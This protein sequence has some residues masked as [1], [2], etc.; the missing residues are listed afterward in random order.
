MH[1]AKKA[2]LVIAAAGVAAGA[3]TTAASAHD[4]QQR[5]EEHEKAFSCSS[6]AA[7]STALSPGLISG[8]GIQVPVSVPINLVGNTVDVIGLLNPAFGNNGICG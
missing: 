4:R 3:S 2:A 7:A 8:N 1:T 5:F 6:V